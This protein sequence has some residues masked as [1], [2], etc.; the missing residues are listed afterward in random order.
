M[1][2]CFAAF[3][4][5]FLQR[6]NLYWVGFGL[7]FVLTLLEVAHGK[8]NNFFTFQ[9]GTFDFWNG[10]DPY[11]VEKYDFLYGP[12]FA[13]L[14]APF[15]YMGATVGP[16]VWNLFNFSMLFWAIFSMPHLTEPQ[17][18]KSYLYLALILATS[19]MSMQYNPAVAYM[20]L[21]AF[22]LLER[23]RPFWAVLL[24][25]IS[26][27]TKIYGIFELA[28]LLC[29]PRVWR[30]LGYA[31][32]LGVLFFVLPLVSLSPEA[33]MPFYHR[34]AEVLSLHTDQFQFYALCNIYWIHSWAAGVLTQIQ[35]GMLGVLALCF[36]ASYRRYGSYTFRIGALAV[37]MG[38]VILFSLSTEKHTYVIA[39]AG[40]LMWY[41]S[42]QSPTLLDRILYWGNLVLL[43]L[44]PVDLVCPPP[45]MRFLCDGVQLNIYCFAITWFRMIYLTFFRPIASSD[46]FRL[47]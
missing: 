17:K 42:L 2:A 14:F 29:Y 36:V 32:A 1:H 31:L 22:I 27:F 43:V 7:T 13:F 39:L 4:R 38:W 24:I 11:G 25:M 8:Q 5:F 35:L 19:Q 3:S 30:N 16:F 33:L 34:W 6:R 37:L 47:R 41:W 21:F 10:A 40:Y 20:F 44:V 46:S 26:G 18:C 15:A 45:V 23:N 9:F 28:L 12:L